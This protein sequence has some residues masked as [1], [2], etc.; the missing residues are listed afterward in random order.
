MLNKEML[1]VATENKNPLKDAHIVVTCAK[2]NV[3]GFNTGGLG[4]INRIP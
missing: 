2:G 4:A 1:L 3:V